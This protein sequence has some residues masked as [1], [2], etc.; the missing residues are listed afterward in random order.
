[1]EVTDVDL[2]CDFYKKYLGFEEGGKVTFEGEEILFLKLGDFQL[3]L[4]HGTNSL[5]NSTH[6]CFE[7]NNL[8]ETIERF[9]QAGFIVDEGPYKLKNGWET[10]FYRGMANEVIEFIENKQS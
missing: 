3:E 8:R 9:S 1:M 6:L 4:I 10:V 5:L 2:V 7:T